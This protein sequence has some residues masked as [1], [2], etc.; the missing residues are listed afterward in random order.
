MCVMRSAVLVI[1]VLHT[2][3]L[4]SLFQC[5]ADTHLS[6]HGDAPGFSIG[7]ILGVRV[8]RVPGGATP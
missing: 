3:H 8:A 2:V 5:T 6:F 7:I 1:R 4:P